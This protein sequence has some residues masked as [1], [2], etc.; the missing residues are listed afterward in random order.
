MKHNRMGT[1][2]GRLERKSMDDLKTEKI[3]KLEDRMKH[4]GH[5]ACVGKCCL[6]VRI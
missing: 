1:D 3:R 2:T 4:G 5:A 6:R